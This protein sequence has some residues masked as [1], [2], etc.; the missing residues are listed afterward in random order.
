M[1]SVLKVVNVIGLLILVLI[2]A[3]PFAWMISTSLKTLPET[4]IFPPDWIPNNPQ[5]QNFIQAWNSG[6]FLHYFMN[7]VFIAV[8]I[9]ILQML[10]IIP[11]AYAFARF[12]FKGSG[13]LF[14]L[15]MVTL[16]IPSQLI[17][18]PVYLQ[19]SSWN[20]LNTHLGLILPFASSA[21]GIF[22]LRQSFKQVPEELIEAA[23]LD[24]A[25]EWKIMW[26]LMIP[27]ARPALITIA[28]F[29]FI[30]HWNDYFWPLVMTTN[31]TARTLPLGI[32]KIRQT[33]GVATWNILMAAN[34]ILVLPI[35][36]V[37][38]FAQRSII[39]AFVY[40]GVK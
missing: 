22:L 30:S 23:R 17:F 15:V 1:N 40:N 13:I 21:F 5:W 37:F 6:P 18:L 2:F 26:K 29:S 25:K 28:L 20:M 4:M 33:E 27:M 11:A 12:Q 31:E 7:S 14:G 32:A 16:M 8:G 9:L 36:V 19:L 38:F 35:L 34:L 10:T 24:K 39:K 3:L